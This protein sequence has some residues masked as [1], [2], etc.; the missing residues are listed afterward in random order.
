MIE[1]IKNNEGLIRQT[2]EEMTVNIENIDYF[3]RFN[4]N[5]KSKELTVIYAS[6]DEKSQKTLNGL[7]DRLLREMLNK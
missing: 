2:F 3:T 1:L 6:I 5:Q 7:V 4:K